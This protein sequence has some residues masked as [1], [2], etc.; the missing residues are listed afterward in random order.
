MTVFVKDP[1]ACRVTAKR[2]RPGPGHGLE[3]G[4]WVAW[5]RVGTADMEE[6]RLTADV[7]TGRE[8]A[9]MGQFGGSAPK[10]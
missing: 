2:V 10:F 8:P 7:L 1:G 5:G 6:S 4:G 3:R 9:K